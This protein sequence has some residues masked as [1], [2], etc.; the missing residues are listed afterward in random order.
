[1]ESQIVI[2]GLTLEQFR[3]ELIEIVRQEVKIA[4]PSN[5]AAIPKLQLCKYCEVS[6]HTIQKWFKD[7]NIYHVTYA[8][9]EEFR[10]RHHKY[11]RRT[12]LL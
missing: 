8:G 3:E 6:Y 1:M 9:L 12:N 5:N 7:D 11:I 10:D 4:E 2:Y